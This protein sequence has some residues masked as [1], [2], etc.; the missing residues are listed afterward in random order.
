MVPFSFP[1]PLLKSR[2]MQKYL[3]GALD[4]GINGLLDNWVQRHAGLELGAFAL[5]CL[6]YFNPGSSF[7]SFLCGQ[8]AFLPK[9]HKN[10]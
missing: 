2:V 7:L 10:D 9:K 5:S 6:P 4:D 3:T 1:Q 8:S